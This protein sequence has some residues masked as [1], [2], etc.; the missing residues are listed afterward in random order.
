MD[1]LDGPEGLLP[2]VHGNGGLQLL[3]PH[4]HQTSD[5]LGL[6]Q[7]EGVLLCLVL[8]RLGQMVAELEGGG[9]EEEEEGRGG[10][11]STRGACCCVTGYSQCRRVS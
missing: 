7:F 2:Q 6:V 9:E 11:R 1:L 10:G 5:H 8:L 3:K 4:V